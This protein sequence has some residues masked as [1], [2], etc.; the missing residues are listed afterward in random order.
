MKNFTVEDIQD[1]EL[2]NRLIE[3]ETN[4]IFESDQARHGRSRNQIEASVQQGKVAE[5][6]LVQTGKFK[7]ADIKWHDLMNASGE[8][9]EVKAYDVNDWNAPS[10]KRDLERYKTERWCKATWY[11][12]FQCR[13][14]EY[15]LL[16]ILRI[17]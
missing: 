12:L 1:K 11:Y 4:R 16:A 5:L 17:K 2:L 13:A 8:Y 14:A 10:V 7:F 3:E 15:K 6:Y 9:I